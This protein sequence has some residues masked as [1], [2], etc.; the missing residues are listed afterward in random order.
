[1][2][3][4]TKN[5]QRKPWLALLLGVVLPPAGFAYVGRYILAFFAIVASLG[6][7]FVAGRAGLIQALPGFYAIFGI[8]LVLRIWMALFPWWVARSK[9]QFKPKWYNRWYHYIWLAL[10]P[11]IPAQWLV[12]HRAQMFGYETF[13]ISSVSMASTI[14]PG[15]FIIV[16]TRPVAGGQIARGDVVTYRPHRAGGKPWLARVVGLPKEEVAVSGNS[17]K[18]N[19]T[20]L[21]EDYLDTDLDP[22][23][24]PLNLNV[25]L[26]EDEFYLLGDNRPNSDDSRFQGP[27]P[28]SHVLGKATAI[29]FSRDISRIC[30]FDQAGN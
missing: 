13:R 11:A 28:R 4:E 16:D 6:L 12:M 8:V 15:E 2:T 9:S 20:P 24:S 10:L 3:S 5:W 1:M 18:I 22:L 14:Q 27:Y 30:S 7:L 29:W 21:V 25:E 26:G 23:L 17:V 19:G